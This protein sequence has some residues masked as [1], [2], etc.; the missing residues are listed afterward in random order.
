[1]GVDKWKVG[2][3]AIK[4][5][6]IDELRE[7]LGIEDATWSGLPDKPETFPPGIHAHEWDEI[8][9]KPETFNPISHH[10]PWEAIT[11]KP[12]TFPPDPHTHDSND[13]SG[14]VT[15]GNSTGEIHGA[16]I[17]VG[18]TNA[19][20]NGSWTIDYSSAGF[21]EVFGVFPSGI[22]KGDDLDDR[23]IAVNGSSAPTNTTASGHLMSAS[24]AGLLVAVTLTKSAGAVR[25]LVIGR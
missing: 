17:W 16:K 3:S 12:Q 22:A 9:G 18:Q 19:D 10:H 14:S 20:G 11:G 24:A 13:I 15:V 5:Q 25:V 23:L 6:H 21:T 8:T 7:I 2:E 1:M 4:Q